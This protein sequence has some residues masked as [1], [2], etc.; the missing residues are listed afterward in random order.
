MKKHCKGEARLIRYADDW[1]CAFQY[2]DDAE[3]FY[4]AVKL[5]LKKF[6]LEL[7]TEK[8]RLVAFSRFAGSKPCLEFLGMEFRWGKDRN[9]Q[10]YLNRRT[11]RKKFRKSVRAF[12]DW[13]RASRHLPLR[14]L[15]EGLKVKLRGY[16]NYY[17]MPGNFAAVDRFRFIIQRVVHKW[18]NRRSE[19]RSY[20]WAGFNEL[21]RHFQFPLPRIRPC[22]MKRYA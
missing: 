18:L 2:Q 19:R 11:S 16:Y 3:R 8:S 20:S 9:G 17:A 22:S 13:C 21:L 1:L 14:R 15:F 4:R 6:G 7:S 12:T 5:R 10:D